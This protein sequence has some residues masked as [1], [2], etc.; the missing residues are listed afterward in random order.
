[1][2]GS[3]A[4]A[5]DAVQGSMVR[6]WRGLDRFDGRSA[7]RTWV[8]RIATGVCPDAPASGMRRA[9]PMDPSG[10]SEGSAPPGLPEDAALWVGPCPGADP[11]AAATSASRCGRH[12]SPC[13]STCTPQAAGHADPAGRPGLLGS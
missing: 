4:E 6:A 1:M 5:Q 10:P 2:V 13:C 11:E 3:Y 12:S 8:Y 9:L 7:L